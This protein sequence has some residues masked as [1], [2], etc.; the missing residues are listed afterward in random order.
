MKKILIS[1]GALAALALSTP[2]FAANNSATANATV[3]LVSPLTLTNTSGLNFGTLVGPFNGETVEVSKSGIRNCGGLTCSGNAV[4]SAA[5]FD[6][7]KGT[8]NQGL[9]VTVDPT[10]T[11]TGSVSGSL[12]VDLSTDLPT[13]VT[14]DTN[15]NA[16]FGVGGSLTIP[17]ATADGVYSGQFNVQVD[18]N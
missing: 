7:S 5:N 14:T 6:V 1:A 8:A 13:G 3:N 4:V 16:T 2:A 15:G 9:T 10:A 17:A 11:L 12:T 18:Y